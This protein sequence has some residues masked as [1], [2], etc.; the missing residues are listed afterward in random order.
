MHP[1]TGDLQVKVTGPNI[2][3]VSVMD[4]REDVSFSREFMNINLHKA[5]SNNMT[6]NLKQH[7]ILVNTE[8]YSAFL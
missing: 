2:G 8:A 3:S 7:V 5:K 1:R 6:Y 4:V